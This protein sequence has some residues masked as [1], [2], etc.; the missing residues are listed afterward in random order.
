MTL[1]FMFLGSGSR[2]N[3]TV[4]RT[5]RF[6]FL[7]D[8][9]FGLRRTTQSLSQ[10]GLCAEDLSAVVL[11]HTHVDHINGPMLR[12]L[13]GAGAELF[14]R[15]EHEDNLSGSVGY[16][17]LKE[18]DR[19]RF[20][21]DEPFELVPGVRVRPLALSHDSPGT[22]GFVFDFD[23]GASGFRF[24]YVA[25][26]GSSS[27]PHLADRLAGADLLALEFNHDEQMELTSG[28]P[29]FLIHRVLGPAGHLSNTN[30]ARLLEQVKSKS[31][32]AV[33]QLHL[34]QECNR[35]QLALEAAAS[36][37][38]DIPIHQT[39]QYRVGPVIRID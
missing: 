29:P 30:A 38:G 12:R 20:F 23:L 5:D 10:F 7:I 14:C 24:A 25:D 6:R 39:N 1:E 35:P 13:A 26:C 2:G 4:V 19:V 21:S 27:L 32:K 15:P 34:S 33:V 28:R 18:Y 36:V 31:L 11:T 17:M 8:L 37:A 3:C 16:R 22:H 9:G